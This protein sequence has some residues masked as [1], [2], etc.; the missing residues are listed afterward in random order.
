MKKKI[1]VLIIGIL[2]LTVSAGYYFFTNF[3]YG[4]F[5]KYQR[6][7]WLFKDSV[8]EDIDKIVCTG[9][10]GKN[11]IEYTFIYKKNYFITIWEFRDL[12]KLDI[13]KTPFYLNQNLDESTIKFGQTEN[14]NVAPFPQIK[15]KFGF[16]IQ[17]QIILYVD[18]DTK[19]LKNIDS[20]NY[21]GFWGNISKMALCDENGDQLIFFDYTLTQQ[22]K[23]LKFIKDSTDNMYISN[24]NNLDSKKYS[25]PTLFILYKKGSNIYLILIN[26]DEIFDDRIINI[27]N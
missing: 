23:N 24:D 10:I 27:L 19:I 8:Q 11:D 21:K 3:H 14:I 18:K 20:D 1:R 6:F 22:P 25:E 5:N 9:L 4:E 17:N 7:I 16:E 26:S 2:L 15:L 13:K 12:L